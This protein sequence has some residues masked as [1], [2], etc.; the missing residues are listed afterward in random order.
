MEQLLYLRAGTT[1][2]Y[3]A[4]K[5]LFLLCIAV[6]LDC[7][8]TFFPVI[9][10]KLNGGD[11]FTG[12]LGT[13]EIVNAFILQLGM[14]F[15]GA[16]L[17]N[18]FH[19][20]VLKDR[21]LAIV[22]TVLVSVL[23]VTRQAITEMNPIFKYVLWIFPPVTKASEVYGNVTAFQLGQTMGVFCLMLGYAVVYG[24]VKGVICHKRLF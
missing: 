1:V 6:L 2:S 18:L 22:L 14:A 12:N 23:S 13:F 16:A 7:F 15:S 24:T 8:Y 4:A 19:P 5:F 17:G 21:K 9:Q 11:M 20:R 3:Y 10:N